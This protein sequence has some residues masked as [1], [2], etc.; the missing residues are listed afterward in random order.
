[1]LSS[2]AAVRTDIYPG[3]RYRHFEKMARGLVRRVSL[4][5]SQS[6]SICP[7]ICDCNPESSTDD[8]HAVLKYNFPT[9]AF[10]QELYEILTLKLIKGFQLDIRLY[11][12][13]ETFGM[14]QG[15]EG[16]V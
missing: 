11:C 5:S 14:G 15:L 7:F 1:M 12:R 8:V 2:F 9:R 10:R 6:A 4:E 16:I 3:L 13:R